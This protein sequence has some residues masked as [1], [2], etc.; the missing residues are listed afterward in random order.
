M[1]NQITALPATLPPGV[2]ESASGGRPRPPVA[3]I[4]PIPRQTTGGGSPAPGASGPLRQ[5]STSAGIPAAAML[6]PQATGQSLSG[7]QTQGT[8]TRQFSTPPTSATPS[9]GAGT[10]GSAFPANTSF[11]N[12]APKQ[13][14]PSQSQDSSWDVT[15]QE[16]TTADGFFDGLDPAR[17]GFIEGDVAVPFMLQSGLDED[18]LAQVW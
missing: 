13:P 15:P 11:G 12:F 16:K 9:G 1:S 7:S 10:F 17:R 4:S 6:Q 2:Y 8:P 3:P 18:T 5:M 14:T